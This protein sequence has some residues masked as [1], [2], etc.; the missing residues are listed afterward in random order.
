MISL[1]FFHLLARKPN[2][3]EKKKKMFSAPVE[4]R[5]PTWW[6]SKALGPAPG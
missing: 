6:P 4:G 3:E 2:L 5:R 1:N